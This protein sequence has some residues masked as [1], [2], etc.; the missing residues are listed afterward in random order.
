MGHADLVFYD[1]IASYMND[2]MPIV[3]RIFCYKLHLH[4]L[5]YKR[6]SFRSFHFEMPTQNHNYDTS[7]DTDDHIEVE[8][9]IFAYNH[10]QDVVQTIGSYQQ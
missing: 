1:D 6:N 8:H 3:H 5:K 2:H 10:L 4:V 9:Y 7:V